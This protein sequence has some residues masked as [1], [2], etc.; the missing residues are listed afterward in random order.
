MQ[1]V[2]DHRR[3]LE[4]LLLHE[5]AVLALADHRAGEGRLLDLAGHRAVF[6]IVH[7]GAILAEL[8]PVALLQIADLVGQ[9]RQGQGVGAEKHLAVAVAHRQGRAPPCADHQVVA[10]GEDDGQG[11]GALPG[12]SG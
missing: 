4:D 9:G 6:G 11:K 12:A 1:G 10:S 5:V 8:D 2:A 3:L 7:L